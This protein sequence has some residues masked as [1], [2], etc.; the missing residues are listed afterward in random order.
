MANT[1]SAAKRARQ[2]ERRTLVNRRIVSYVKN[3]L[4]S[5]REA[6]KSGNKVEAQNAAQRFVSALDKAVKSGNVH[7]NSAARHKSV[8]GKAL[9][10]LA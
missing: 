3:S 10:S 9:A 4:K 8:I 5:A 2:S 6:L 7:R 1:P